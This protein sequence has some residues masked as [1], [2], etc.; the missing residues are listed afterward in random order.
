M[1][2]AF[3]A[4]EDGYCADLL[5]ID[6]SKA[7]DRVDIT[8]A[9]HKLIQMEVRRELLPWIGDFLRDRKQMVKVNGTTSEWSQVTCG[10]P[11]G[12]KVGPVVFLAMVNNVLE[13]HKDRWKFVDDITVSA[14]S[15]PLISNNTTL[16]NIMME[17][18]EQAEQEHMVINTA[19]CATMRITTAT[20]TT[21]DPITINGTQIPHVNSM[22]LLGIVIQSNLKW[23]KQIEAMV[24]KANTQTTSSLF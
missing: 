9:L 15:K 10:V 12:T 22:K 7:F 20:K 1:Q 21:F 17:T 18:I 13:N 11:Q 3:Q 2:H 6:Y 23:D 19:K 16:Q 5:A 8:V 24:A 4:L 14:L